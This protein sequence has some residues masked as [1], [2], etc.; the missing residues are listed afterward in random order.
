MQYSC[1][2]CPPAWFT[3]NY[4]NHSWAQNATAMVSNIYHREWTT[5]QT[6]YV[7]WRIQP[8]QCAVGCESANFPLTWQSSSVWLDQRK[9]ILQ[10]TVVSCAVL[11]FNKGMWLLGMLIQRGGQTPKQTGLRVV[12]VLYSKAYLE[13]SNLAKGSSG[14]NIYLS[15]SVQN[16]NAALGQNRKEDAGVSAMHRESS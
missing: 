11:K 6:E 5:L 15:K 9:C 16:H 1:A 8:N 7:P 13:P 4:K 12:S 2:G 3:W 14:R 10:S